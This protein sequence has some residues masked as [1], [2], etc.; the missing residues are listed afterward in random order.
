[1]IDLAVRGP[2]EQILRCARSLGADLPEPV[3]ELEAARRRF[4]T[5]ASTLGPEPGRLVD[6]VRAAIDNGQD[7]ASDPEVQRLVTATSLAGNRELHDQLNH[8]GLGELRTAIL[9]HTDE[10][11]DTWRPAFDAA[12]DA[13]TTAL[14]TLGTGRRGSL[15]RQPDHDQAAARAWAEATT[16][17]STIRQVRG[18]AAALHQ[19]PTRGAGHRIPVVLHIADADAT[20]LPHQVQD[21][22]YALAAHATLH[23]ADTAALARR[24]RHLRDA[25]RPEPDPA[26]THSAQ[27]Q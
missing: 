18:A 8:F 3:A 13:I 14:D 11:L 6:A 1:M 5:A 26:P 12:V 25:R 19:L 23:L 9:E 4:D 2:I 21:D 17:I 27:L 22:P 15:P 20:R 10:I 16:A 24:V 7:P